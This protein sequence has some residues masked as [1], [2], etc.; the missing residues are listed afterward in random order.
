MSVEYKGKKFK[1]KNVK[2]SGLHL[3]IRGKKIENISLIERLDQ[4]PNLVSLNLA[5]NQ[6]T[7]ISGLSDLKALRSLNLSDNK[8]TEIKGLENL[9]NLKTLILERNQISE[10]KG[11]ENLENLNHLSLSNNNISE[12]KGLENLTNLDTLYMFRNPI[13]DWIREDIGSFQLAKSA[14]KYCARKTGKAQFKLEE[15]DK[16]LS[17]KKQEISNAVQEKKY[18][19][20][21]KLLRELHNELKIDDPNMYYK[22]IGEFLLEYPNLFE[23]K[24]FIREYMA[25]IDYIVSP[26]QGFNM[27]TYVINNYCTYENEETIISFYGQIKSHSM[28]Y[29]GRIHITNFRIFVFGRKEED[30]RKFIPLPFAGIVQDIVR[31]SV[32]S[33]GKMI[34]GKY[35]RAGKMPSFGYQLPLINLVKKE[36]ED[37]FLDIQCKISGTKFKMKIYPKQLKDEN[38]HELSERIRHLASILPQVE[39]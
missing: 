1:V 13:F 37:E 15:V 16:L 9:I 29:K 11:L 27:E 2:G 33:D 32:K 8:I 3:E 17:V 21:M 7:E 39:N 24:K 23:Q 10:I 26:K 25:E 19:E 18:H 30:N 6:I 38:E 34:M 31:M 4:F 22:T 35:G 14:V 12:L 20:L 28:I 5:E 36:V